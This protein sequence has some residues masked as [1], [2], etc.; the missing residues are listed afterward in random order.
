M[1]RDFFSTDYIQQTDP[2]VC[3]HIDSKFQ[4]DAFVDVFPLE[5]Q[6]FFADSNI[7]FIQKS[8]KSHG[9][10]DAPDKNTVIQIMSQTYNFNLPH[11]A[12]NFFEAGKD[13]FNSKYAKQYVSKLN[14]IVIDR[15]VEN[16]S[17]M[18]FVQQQYFRDIMQPRGVLGIERPLSTNCKLRGDNILH[19]AR[20]LPRMNNSK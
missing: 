10:N 3:F 16:M 15:L 13:S 6:L 8:V 5:H 4:K 1:Q 7:Q 9:F 14:N 2:K 17:K 18:R 19:S 11:G 20:L 12:Y